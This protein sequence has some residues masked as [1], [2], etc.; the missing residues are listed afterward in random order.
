MGTNNTNIHQMKTPLRQKVN[1]LSNKC[2]I[3]EA[4]MNALQV[5]LATQAYKADNNI[6]TITSTEAKALPRNGQF[7][8]KEIKDEKTEELL[9]VEI[10]F[11]VP[12]AIIKKDKEKE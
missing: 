2:A 10:S 3:M 11:K 7:N 6:I 8:I 9:S 4:E 12:S 1:A 5:F